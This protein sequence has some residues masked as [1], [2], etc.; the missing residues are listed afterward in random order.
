M[1]ARVLAV[2]AA[3]G[4]IGG[5]FAYRYGLPGSDD[6]GAGGGDRGGA[7]YCAAELGP[8]C[9]GLGGR[10]VTEPAAKTAATLIG[11]RDAGQAGIGGWLAPGPWPAMVDDARK[12]GSKAP[13]FSARGET[14]ASTDLA[15]VARKGQFP[16]GCAPL[17]WKC[18]GDAAQNPEFKIGADPATDA[19]GLF[20]RAAAV[21][22]F[23]GRSDFATNDLD[24]PQDA[25][26]WLDNL[27]RRLDS[28]A[29]FGAG[30]LEDFAIKQGSARVYLTTAAAAGKVVGGSPQF[31]VA[32]P[33]TVVR[34]T[35]AYTPAV[36]SPAGIDTDRVRGSLR[37][38]GWEKAEPDATG[39]GL[40]SPG[41]LLALSEVA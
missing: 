35:A 9:D 11:A 22:G 16:D 20:V 33:A 28:A 30:S 10:A 7:V 12:L 26:S 2:L 19:V 15:A 37:E 21:G 27:D 40:P 3:L 36:S 29:A 39:A 41:V 18:L 13:I 8:V 5:A 32:A 31:E 6:G 24:D 17:T 4:M 23:L 1:V 38:A 14:L 25:R 34:I